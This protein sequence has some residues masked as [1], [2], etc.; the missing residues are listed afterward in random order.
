MPAF[1]CRP[2]TTAEKETFH[3]VKETAAVKQRKRAEKNERKAVEKR[4]H[5][6]QM[7]RSSIKTKST[8]QEQEKEVS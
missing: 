2:M 7:K 6:Q 5:E 4:L 1:M 8:T 3:D